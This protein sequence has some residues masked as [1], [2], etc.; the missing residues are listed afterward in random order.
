MPKPDPLSNYFSGLL[1]VIDL[2]TRCYRNGEGNFQ[3][4]VSN[5]KGFIDYSTSGGPTDRGD[6][7]K[8]EED[9]R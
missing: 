2:W 5:D 4:K 3:V 9:P 1:A 7:P 6:K 8:G